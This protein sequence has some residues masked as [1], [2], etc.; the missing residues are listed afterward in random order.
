MISHEKLIEMIPVLI[1]KAV[2]KVI[3]LSKVFFLSTICLFEMCL[4]KNATE[5]PQNVYSTVNTYNLKYNTLFDWG[6]W[7]RC[8]LEKWAEWDVIMF[9]LSLEQ[10][11]TRSCL[12]ELE[13]P[14]LLDSHRGPSW[15]VETGSGRTRIHSWSAWMGVAFPHRRPL[16]GYFSVTGNHNK[17]GAKSFPG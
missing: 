15:L 14:P 9:F 10:Q 5:V 17:Y 16:I 6:R 1:C 12:T 7:N 11:W 8:F 13:L 3:H 2:A 4:S